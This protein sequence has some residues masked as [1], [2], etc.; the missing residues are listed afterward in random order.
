MT[1]E[2]AKTNHSMHYHAQ[3]ILSTNYWFNVAR[4]TDL[5]SVQ[6]LERLPA[7]IVTVMSGLNTF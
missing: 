5:H 2:E 1:P 6:Y 3:I 7:Y 4:V